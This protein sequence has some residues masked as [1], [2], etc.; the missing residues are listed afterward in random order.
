M[1]RPI[2]PTSLERQMAFLETALG[3]LD[4]ERAV[5]EAVEDERAYGDDGKA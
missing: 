1:A 5:F 4:T 3:S 2:S